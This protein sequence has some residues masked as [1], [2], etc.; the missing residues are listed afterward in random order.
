MKVAFTFDAEHADNPAS[1][2]A[3]VARILDALA[4]QAVRA[5]FFIQGRWAKCYPDYARRIAGEGH[6]IGSHS[7]FHAPMTAFTP[8]GMASDLK[9]AA[10]CIQA[11]TGVDP[12][13]WFRPPFG[14]R[15]SAGEAVLK[16]NG[17][18]SIMWTL[19]SMDW[20][21]SSTKQLGGIVASGLQDGAVVLMHTWPNVTALAL[22]DILR[23]AAERGAEMVRVDEL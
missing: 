9:Q 2:S 22:P 19:A 7:H 10:G 4:A 6:L 11:A 5:T 16:A 17:Y 15:S 20:S 14:Y 3:N 13:P 23:S 18:K 21:V 1:D 8:G 12:A